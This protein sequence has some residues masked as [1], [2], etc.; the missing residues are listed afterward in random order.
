MNVVYTQY[1]G[2]VSVLKAEAAKESPKAK[3]AK[4]EPTRSGQKALQLD[5][6]AEADIAEVRL[7]LASSSNVV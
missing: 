2:S 5:E 6:K 3:K 7:F 1:N 4:T